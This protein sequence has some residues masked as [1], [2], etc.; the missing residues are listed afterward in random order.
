MAGMTVQVCCASGCPPKR[1]YE[2]YEVCL[3]SG[4]QVNIVDP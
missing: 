2:F 4:S 3:D 1:L